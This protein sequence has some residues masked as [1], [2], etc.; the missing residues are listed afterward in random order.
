MEDLL[1]PRG[2]VLETLSKMEQ[3]LWDQ[4]DQG[5]ILKDFQQALEP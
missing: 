4:V 3:F 2:T 5:M 1:V